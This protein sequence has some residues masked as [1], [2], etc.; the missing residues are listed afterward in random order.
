MKH[1][2]ELNIYDICKVKI[3]TTRPL[4]IDPYR[5]NRITRSVILVDDETN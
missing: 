2:K 4:M 5:K 3:L 1:I